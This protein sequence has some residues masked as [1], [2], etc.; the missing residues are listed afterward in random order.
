MAQK[1]EDA[2]RVFVVVSMQ[3]HSA[4]VPRCQGRGKGNSHEELCEAAADAGL[5]DLLD[6]VVRTVR[7]VRQR[8]AGVCEDLLVL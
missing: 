6:L 1:N 2:V 7:Q 3:E 4:N 5:D 8:P